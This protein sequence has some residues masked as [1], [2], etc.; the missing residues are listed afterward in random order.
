MQS[1]ACHRSPV[2]HYPSVYKYDLA[3]LWHI[4]TGLPFVFA[5]WI[6]RKEAI[7]KKKDLIMKLSIDLI[8]ANRYASGKL[9]FIAK[10][11][12][13]KKWLT[14]KALVGYWKKISYDLTDKHMEGLRLFEKYAKNL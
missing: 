4:H 7:S 6:V 13:R 3:E 14:E 1:I 11:F 10:E 2:T 12:P 9:A 8:N 5:L